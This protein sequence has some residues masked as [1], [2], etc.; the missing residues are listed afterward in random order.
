MKIY[1]YNYDKK[2]PKL[3]IYHIIYKV[4]DLINNKFYIGK[5][6]T[7][8]INDDYLGS[9]KIILR[10][11]KKYGK[12]NFKKE[13]LYIFDCEKEAYEVEYNLLT[14]DIIN[15]KKNY[16]LV[17]GGKG[18]SS[19]LISGKNHPFYG[20][21]SPFKNHKHSEETKKKM[22]ISAIG[23][24]VS[25]EVRKKLSKF[26]TGKKLSE[27]TKKKIS[28]TSSGINNGMYGKTHSEETRKKIGLANSNPSKET[29]KKISESLT[30]RKIPE[31]VGKKISKAL[32]GKK[33][34]KEH[35]QKLSQF[36][37]MNKNGIT[38][39]IKLNEIP[40][41]LNNNWVFGRVKKN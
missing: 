25:Q 7:K 6:T 17:L 8:N 31:S 11:I 18:F 21:D 9:G 39:K 10:S 35:K 20:K 27:E 40:N 41:H 26:H 15:D 32:K 23:H 22:S 1:D 36:K 3:E 13:I 29:R 33:F 12:E 30:G 38:K 19:E 37:W 34:S 5:H 2:I 14:L 24:K 28:I 16:N 4:T